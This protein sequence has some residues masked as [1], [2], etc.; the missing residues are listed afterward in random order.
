M[1]PVPGAPP[2]S[3]EDSGSVSADAEA[4]GC[5]SKTVRKGGGRSAALRPVPPPSSFT[6]VVTACG[7]HRV[8]GPEE[9]GRIL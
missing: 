2:S 9:E 3:R 4:H 1:I 8:P 5:V 6:P 7:A